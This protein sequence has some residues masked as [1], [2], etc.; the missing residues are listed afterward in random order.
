[1]TEF[2]FEIVYKK[3]SEMPADYLSRNFVDAIFL[4]DLSIKT[5]QEKEP[6]YV[7]LKAFLLYGTP[8]PNLA[9]TQAFESVAANCFVQNNILWRCFKSLARSYACFHPP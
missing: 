7:A 9:K 8:H 4:D 2:D 3:G 6:D 5:E 1:M